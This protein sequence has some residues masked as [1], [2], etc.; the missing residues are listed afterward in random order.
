[1][2]S[3]KNNFLNIE[4]AIRLT[5]TSEST[6]RRFIRSLDS[7]QRKKYTFKDGRRIMLDKLF[8]CS[9][10][11]IVQDGHSDD[12]VE[13]Q[14]KT[15]QDAHRMTD[16]LSKQNDRLLSE[17]AKASDDLKTA[18]SLIDQLKNEVFRLT[19]EVKR[20]ESP[21][22]EGSSFLVYLVGAVCLFAV[23]VLVYVL[24]G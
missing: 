13:L 2:T 16:H 14:R 1:M 18:W 12:L 10:F 9:A 6:I 11:G 7:E 22:D 3:Q 19:S 15:I 21:K 4:D 24:V 20:L 5:G 8:V 23:V 17:L